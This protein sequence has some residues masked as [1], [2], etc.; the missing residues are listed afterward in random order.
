MRKRRRQEPEHENSERWLLTYADLI[1]LLL[2]LFV[3][4]YA[5]SKIDTPRY[6]ELVAAMTGIFGKGE[7]GVIQGHI[8]MVPPPV[9]GAGGDERRKIEE[10]VKKEM[11]AAIAA[12]FTSVEEN[13]RGVTVHMMEELLFPSGSADLKEGSL[14]VLDPLASVLNKIPNDIRVEGHTDNVPIHNDRYPSNWH[15]SVSRAMT[16]AYY[17]IEQHRLTP[18]KISVAGYS[19]YR[20]LLPN[21]TAENRA[22]NRRVDIVIV[23]GEPRKTARSG[24]KE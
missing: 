5:M 6:G 4:L 3:I 13:E 22:R 16:T 2:G 23:A 20:P 18:G 17:L 24:G 21:T 12:G 19:E 7:H 1:T 15:L 11:S 10:A 14:K 9:A 8:G